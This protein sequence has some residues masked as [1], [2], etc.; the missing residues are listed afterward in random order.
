MQNNS[1]R[2][3]N[4]FYRNRGNNSGSRKINP[5][6]AHTSNFKRLTQND[7]NSNS[8]KSAA[9]A[10]GTIIPMLQ[11]KANADSN[12]DK[13]IEAIQPTL[14]SLF[15]HLASFITTDKYYVPTFP[16]APKVPWTAANDP[17]E[18]NQTIEKAKANEYAK[19]AAKLH[20]DKPRM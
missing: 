1:N 12:L 9:D 20:A 18:I 6:R 10:Q 19:L 7:F 13:W 2:T 17:G 11:Y 16:K 3:K 15:G 8:I 5:L 4:N 14:E